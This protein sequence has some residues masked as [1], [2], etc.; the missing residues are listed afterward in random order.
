MKSHF[1]FSYAA[2]YWHIDKSV[3]QILSI[4]HNYLIQI[5]NQVMYR[6]IFYLLL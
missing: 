2:S 6:K 4:F 1:W 3:F 5:K